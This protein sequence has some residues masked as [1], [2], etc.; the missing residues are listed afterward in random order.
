MGITLKLSYKNLS[1]VV[2]LFEQ[3]IGM[4]LEHDPTFKK[5][6]DIQ[7]YD[8]E[9]HDLTKKYGLPSGRLYRAYHDGELAGCIALRKLDNENCEMKRLYV[10]PQFRG[11]RIGGM[12]VEK[13]IED[14]RH[15]G[16]KYMFLDTL[17]SLKSAITLYKSYGFYDTECYNDSPIEGT[18]FMKFD[19]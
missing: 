13:V 16:Y 1:E 11:K 3:Y 8:K 18:V 12:L 9:L 14:A 10:K 7:N 4:L 17:P 19:L 15:I 6:L 2:E 5:Y